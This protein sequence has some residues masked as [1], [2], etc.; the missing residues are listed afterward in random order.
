MQLQTAAPTLPPAAAAAPLFDL[1]ELD[2]LERT[3]AAAEDC[4][5][6]L[7]MRRERLTCELERITRPAPLTPRIVGPGFTYRGEMVR[8]YSAIDIYA[9]LLRRLWID[10]PERRES[11]ARAMRARGYTRGYVARTGAELF[12]GKPPAWATKFCRPL[13]DDWLID[14]NLNRPR[15]AMLLR[16]AVGEAGL[17]WMEAVQVYWRATRT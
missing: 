9:Q 2:Q 1:Q 14:T 10:F 13:V 12:P 6:T 15:I 7:R 8:A 4:L 3:I 16:V 11:M 5:A 17:K